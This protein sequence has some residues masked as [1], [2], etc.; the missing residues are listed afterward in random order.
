MSSIQSA[1]GMS[2]ATGTSAAGT[3]ETIPPQ[4]SSFAPTA[5]SQ[6]YRR[7]LSPLYFFRGSEPNGF[8]SNW[9]DSEPFTDCPDTKVKATTNMKV[10]KT[11][12]HYMMH[13]KAL[14]FG[15]TKIA[16][17]ILHVGNP[18]KAKSLGR[19]VQGFHNEVW[20][21]ERMRIVSDAIYWKFTGPL[22]SLNPQNDRD[23]YDETRERDWKLSD[24]IWAETM[25]ARS[26][27][28]ALLATGD[29]LLVEASPFDRIWGIG[30]GAQKADE[31]RDKW[32]LNLLGRCLMDVRERFRGERGDVMDG[33]NSNEGVGKDEVAAT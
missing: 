11:A 1:P 20:E 13:H 24:S 3:S 15:D 16:T 9:Y 6:L 33:E 27:R 23:G 14:L 21:R 26:F 29:R 7:D 5:V 32:G 2:T 25:R 4:I 8:L 12:E 30:F 18:R 10:Y 17:Q 31:N 28:A 19:S 22:S